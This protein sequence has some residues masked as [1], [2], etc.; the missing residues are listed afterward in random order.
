MKKVKL[1]YQNHIVSLNPPNDI[2]VIGVMSNK[3]ERTNELKILHSWA[4]EEI[5]DIFGS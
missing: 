1:K 3:L 5:N 4:L 2:D